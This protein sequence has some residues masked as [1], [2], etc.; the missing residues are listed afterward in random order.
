MLYLGYSLTF[1]ITLGEGRVGVGWRTIDALEE[2]RGAKRD[3]VQ[4]QEQSVRYDV[5]YCLSPDLLLSHSRSEQVNLL[6]K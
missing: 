1:R 3:T 2:R 4:R 5:E 6:E